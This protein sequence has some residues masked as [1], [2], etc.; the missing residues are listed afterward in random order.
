MHPSGSA[1]LNCHNP[2]GV[3]LL[4]KLRLGKLKCR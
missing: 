4:T 3:V 1:D 2:K